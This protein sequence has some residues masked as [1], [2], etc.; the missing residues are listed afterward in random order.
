[1]WVSL[2]RLWDKIWEEYEQILSTQLAEQSESFVKFTHDQNMWQYGTR[3]ARYMS[4]N[5]LAYLGTRFDL[6]VWLLYAFCSWTDTTFQLQLC[7]LR[8][9]KMFLQVHFIWFERPYNF[10]VA[11][12]VSFL[13]ICFE[14]VEVKYTFV[15]HILF[16]QDHILQNALFPLFL[17]RKVLWKLF[18]FE[19]RIVLLFRAYFEIFWV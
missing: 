3:Q 6:E 4:W 2:K 5:F 19:Y 18:L 11:T 17:E 15:F 7:I 9:L 14:E 16:V 8:T 1:M 13:L 10:L 12:S